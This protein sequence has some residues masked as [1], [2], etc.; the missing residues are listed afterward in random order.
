LH[1]PC[2]R[3]A[4]TFDLEVAGLRYSVTVGLFPTGTPAEVFISNHKVGNASDVMARD[5]GILISLLLQY[6]CTAELIA[7]SI[8]CNG[9]SPPRSVIG[10]VLDLI[11]G[12]SGE[13]CAK[14]SATPITADCTSRGSFHRPLDPSQ[15]DVEA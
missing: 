6:G 9:T 4:E 13:T 1:L 8:N 15:P 7:N 11:I 10:T 12:L 2:R 3:H 14:S 5:A